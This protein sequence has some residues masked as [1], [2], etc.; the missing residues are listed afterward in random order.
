MSTV[1]DARG[2]LPQWIQ[3][4]AIPKKIAVD[5]PL[6]LSFMHE[7]CRKPGWPGGIGLELESQAEV[8]QSASKTGE[9]ETER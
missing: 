5:V 1:S 7:N 4:P 6:V 8:P 2:A 9:A 3:K